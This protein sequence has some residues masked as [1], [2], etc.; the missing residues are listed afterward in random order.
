MAAP[1]VLVVTGASGTQGSA[2]IA[3]LSSRPENGRLLQIRAI[4]RDSSNRRCERL[5]AMARRAA[6]NTTL[7][8]HEAD[9]SDHQALSS[10]LTGAFAVYLNTSP[11]YE[12]P[13]NEV[14]HAKNIISA[15]E[16]SDS[17]RLIVYASVVGLDDSEVWNRVGGPASWVKSMA[18]SPESVPPLILPAKSSLLPE[19]MDE[20]A[21]VALQGYFSAKY[22]IEQLVVD[23]S[24]QK[25][26]TSRSRAWSILRPAWFMTDFVG[27]K[28]S[29]HWPELP[30]RN[31]LRTSMLPVDRMMLVAPSDIGTIASSII[32]Q[33]MLGD[34]K[35]RIINVGSDACSMEQIA[36]G[37]THAADNPVTVEYVGVE[38]ANREIREGNRFREVQAWCMPR[39]NCFD[40]G[41]LQDMFGI[42]LT[43]FKSFLAQD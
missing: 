30:L 8:I 36:N 23:W 6:T 17:V 14:E 37:L 43:S 13:R 2:L 1:L 29:H 31:T 18:A 39:Q 40:P 32:R 15:A 10:V 11:T 16:K 19:T 28:A 27:S 33:G 38:E 9:F 3:A 42:R 35:G 21:R 26:K 4:V 25:R 7:T 5:L 12:N 41:R 34:V 22:Q 20:K 24:N